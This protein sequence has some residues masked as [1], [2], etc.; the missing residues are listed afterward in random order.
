MEDDGAMT[1]ISFTVPSRRF[2]AGNSM[3]KAMKNVRKPR[4]L[5]SD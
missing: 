1:E 2:S 5:L 4:K 3:N